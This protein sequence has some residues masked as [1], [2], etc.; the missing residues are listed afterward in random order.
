VSVGGGLVGIVL[1]AI[2]AKAINLFAGW[3]TV[4]SLLGVVVA[5]GISVAIGI[6]FG[7]Y[8]ARKAA[9]LDPIEAL[10]YE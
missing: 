6:V 7:I 3:E 1:G 5:F 8:P 9:D 10:R 2:M 4:I